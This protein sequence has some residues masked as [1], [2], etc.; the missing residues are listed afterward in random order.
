M[1][2]DGEPFGGNLRWFGESWGAPVCLP[3]A[4]IATPVGMV[5]AG[6]QHLHGALVPDDIRE[7][8][9]GV[10]IPYLDGDGGVITIGF[11]LSCWFHELGIDEYGTRP[12]ES[13]GEPS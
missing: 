4:H 3:A 7:G 11:H 9:Q 13:I 2:D 12:D 5:C 1:T 6:H 10:T 8:D